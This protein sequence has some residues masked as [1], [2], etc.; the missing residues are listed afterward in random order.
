VGSLGSTPGPDPT[1]S[2]AFLRTGRWPAIDQPL[3]AQARECRQL[4]V[5]HSKRTPE[6][7]CTQTSVHRRIDGRAPFGAFGGRV[8]TLWRQVS[9]QYFKSDSSSSPEA[10]TYT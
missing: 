10:S 9:I 8:S 4:P 3:N 2:S 5:R 6:L 7:Q 1:E